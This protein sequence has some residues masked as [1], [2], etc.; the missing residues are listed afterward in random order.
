M[1]NNKKLVIQPKIEAPKKY[2]TLRKIKAE[3]RKQLAAKNSALRVVD[4]TGMID[5]PKS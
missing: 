5:W 1:N 3:R 4:T 2:I